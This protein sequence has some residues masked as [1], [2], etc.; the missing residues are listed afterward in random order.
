MP[1]KKSV[2]WRDM[3][4]LFI[5]SMTTPYLVQY[6]SSLTEDQSLQKFITLVSNLVWYFILWIMVTKVERRSMA[7][8]GIEDRYWGRQ[9]LWGILLGAVLFLVLGLVPILLQSEEII[10]NSF[11]PKSL[12]GEMLY[13]FFLEFFF[14]AQVEEKVFRGYY[15][16]RLEEATGSR[17]LAACG[18]TALFI[19]PH[20]V[21]RGFSL[22]LISIVVL[23]AVLTFVRLRLKNY[24]ML[25]LILAHGIYNFALDVFPAYWMIF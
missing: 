24:S 11:A 10:F 13:C 7:A 2:L 22:S 23:G 1:L 19:I 21:T 18:A 20:I 15:L 12:R 25:T 6:L 14:V 4:V 17:L 8:F 16:A 5:C 3:I 9:I